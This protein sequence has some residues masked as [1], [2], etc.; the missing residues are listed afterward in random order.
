MILGWVVALLMTVVA[1]VIG[2]SWWLTAPLEEPTV[3]PPV[4]ATPEP[5]PMVRNQ[6]QPVD[7]PEGEVKGLAAKRLL[8]RSLE[9]ASDQLG[10]STGYTA[11]FR[12]QERLNGKLGTEQTLA[13]KV[14]HEPFAI[15]LKFLA[16][17]PG[18]EVVYA[19]GHHD[20]QII[21]H[22]GDWTRKLV[23]RLKVAPDSAVALADSRHPITEAGL[24]NLVRRLARFRVLDLT[25]DDAETILDRLTDAEGRDWLRSVHLHTIRTDERP[26]MRVEVLYDHATRYPMQISNFDWPEPGQTGDLHLA[27]R[28]RYDDVKLDAALGPID[29]DPANPDYAFMRF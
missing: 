9:Q 17:K 23:P 25:D 8:L 13:M 4:A 24:L 29:F 11:T 7:W 10:R 15:Y 6:D 22:N 16:P 21:A 27:E 5:G 28:Y 2:V 12:K 19:E 1:V 3:P 18:K 26:F 14:R 20:N